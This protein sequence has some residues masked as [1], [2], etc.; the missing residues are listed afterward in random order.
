MLSSCGGAAISAATSPRPCGYV[1]RRPPSASPGTPRRCASGP[2]PRSSPVGVLESAAAAAAAAGIADRPRR[3]V[4]D[5]FLAR[6]RR[7]VGWRPPGV[8]SAEHP[9]RGPGA[10]LGG[11]VCGAG[12]LL[13]ERAPQGH[14]RRGHRGGA[15]AA[16]RRSPRLRRLPLG[17]AL[18]GER[19]ADRA[20][21]HRRHRAQRDG[22]F[23]RAS[24]RA[25]PCPG[26]RHFQRCLGGAAWAR[27]FQRR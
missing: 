4:A 9:A 20:R 10:F 1:R 8:D 25:V 23:G 7:W 2:R 6:P 13:D 24:W 15:E 14:H 27:C 16:P 11:S 18:L 26:I 5:L 22:D 21:A 19:R 12:L 17:G 3:R